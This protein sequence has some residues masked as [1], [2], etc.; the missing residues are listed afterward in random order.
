MGAGMLCLQNAS[1]SLQ[2]VTFSNNQ[3]WA[4]D[5]EAVGGGGAAF[6]WGGPGASCPVT[7]D[8][9]TF[10]SNEVHAGSTNDAP[11]GGHGLG[12]GF[13]ITHSDLTATN[14]TLTGNKV[15]GGNG[16]GGVR[17]VIWAERTLWAEEPPFNTAMPRLIMFS[18]PTITRMRQR[19]GFRRLGAGGG[20]FFELGVGTVISATITG[21]SVRGGDSP[22]GTGGIGAGGG[23]MTERQILTID[24]ARVINNISSGGNGPN[25]GHA[26]GGGIYLTEPRGSDP[27]PSRLTASNIVIAG[28][29]TEAGSGIARWGGGGAIFSQNTN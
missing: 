16:G 12:G 25:S 28:N 4:P 11:R 24:R 10:D 1:V 21:N 15:W 5:T 18:P 27:S 7:M 17:T 8:N 9:V 13:F 20:L 6:L 19:S 29:R 26:G 3:V 14:L 2:N 22:S 23:I